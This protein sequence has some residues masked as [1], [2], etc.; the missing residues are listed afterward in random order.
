MFAKEVC[1]SATRIFSVMWYR[2]LFLTFASIV[3]EQ[4]HPHT[5]GFR[6]KA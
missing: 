5:T 3:M 4:N 2:A 6:E 1:V